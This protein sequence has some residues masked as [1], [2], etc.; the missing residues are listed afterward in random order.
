MI[1][2]IAFRPSGSPALAPTEPTRVTLLWWEAGDLVLVAPPPSAPAGTHATT[3]VAAWPSQE[4][5]LWHLTEQQVAR[6][7]ELHT[8]WPW[9]LDAHDVRAYPDG[10]IGPCMDSSRGLLGDV[11]AL[12][13]RLAAVLASEA[14]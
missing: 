14:A 12:V 9:K 10:R 4:V 13:D 11:S 3:I 7:Y 2:R 5:M 1:R 6:L 8:Q